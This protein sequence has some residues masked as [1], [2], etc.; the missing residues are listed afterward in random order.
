MT[1]HQGSLEREAARLAA[2]VEDALA[3]AAR[4]AVEDVAAPVGHARDGRWLGFSPGDEDPEGAETG[5]AGDERK[6]YEISMRGGESFEHSLRDPARALDAYTFYLPRVRSKTLRARLRLC[7]GR[8][9][10]L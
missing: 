4:R 2:S 7:A 10:G 1:E 6:F 9:A 3:E 8:S 5:L